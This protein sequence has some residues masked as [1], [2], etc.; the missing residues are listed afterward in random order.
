MLTRSDLEFRA[1]YWDDPQAKQAFKDFILKIHGLDFTEWDEGGF[2]DPAYTPFSYFLGDQMVASV[3]IYLLEARIEGHATRLVQISGVGTLEEWRRKGL[4]RDLTRRGLEWAQGKYSGLFLFADDAAIPYYRR[5]GFQEFNEFVESLEVTA[6]ER[7]SGLKRL[8]PGLATDLSKIYTLA[9]KHDPI[10]DIL[11][12]DNPKLVMFHALYTLRDCVYEIPDLGCILFFRRQTN[13][14]TIYDIL[15]EKLPN[16]ADLYPYL[17][18]TADRR[19]EFRFFT[20][21]LGL[22][23]TVKLPLLGD[24]PFTVGR[25]P[26]TEVVIPFTARA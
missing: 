25:F 23:Q 5:T 14:V 20:D 12:V 15:A 26:L 3:C 11:S 8:D 19:I 9:S 24:N 6:P 1:L 18:E 4:S 13:T 10:S 7:I 22:E 16:F 17:A 21:K 2:W